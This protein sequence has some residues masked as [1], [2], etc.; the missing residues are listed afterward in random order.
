MA[1]PT[2]CLLLNLVLAAALIG[3]MHSAQAGN[4]GQPSRILLQQHGHHHCLPETADTFSD[5]LLGGEG[6]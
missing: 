2:G 5:G 4:I 1:L 3:A 6:K